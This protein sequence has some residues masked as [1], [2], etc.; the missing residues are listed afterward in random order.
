MVDKIELIKKIFNIIYQ[1]SS[2][3]HESILS[4]TVGFS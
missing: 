4:K 2:E 1:R 3:E